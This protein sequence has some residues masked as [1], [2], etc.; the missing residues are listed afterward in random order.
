[1]TTDLSLTN[2][3]EGKP[4]RII[5]QN[6]EVWIPIADIAGAWGIA[7]STPDKILIRNMDVFDGLSIPLVDVTSNTTVV[8]LNERGL[9]L[10]MGKITASRLKNPLAKESIIKFQKWYPELI[11]KY[12][13][14]EIVQLPKGPD[15]PGIIQKL[16]FIRSVHE[17]TGWNLLELQ[18]EVLREAGMISLTYHIEPERKVLHAAPLT[19]KVWLTPTDI[20]KE[21]GKNAQEINQWL[22]NNDYQ[23]KDQQ[24]EE[25]RIMPKGKSVG[26]EERYEQYESG[27][28]GWHIVWN[29]AVLRLFN[30]HD[31]MGMD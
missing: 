20:G 28:F 31:H 22:W 27:H 10:M 11:Q 25:W 26:G 6:N 5:E 12:R 14:K 23:R 4:V 19:L 15:Y 2:L 8:C 18:K 13:K 17:E 29:R 30:I 16:K 1:M 24:T 7:R 3:F 9:Y 21:C